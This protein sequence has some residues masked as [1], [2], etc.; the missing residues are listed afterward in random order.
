MQFALFLKW[1]CIVFLPAQHPLPLEN[2][3]FPL[4]WESHIVQGS[5]PGFVQGL[6][7]RLSLCVNPTYKDRVG[8]MKRG[9]LRMTPSSDEKWREKEIEI[10]IHANIQPCL[11][12]AI[13]WSS[14]LD[15][16]NF[17]FVLFKLGFLNLQQWLAQNKCIISFIMLVR[18]RKW[19][20]KKRLQ[21]EER[22][23]KTSKVLPL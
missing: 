4:L 19:R 7:Q 13:L 12:P 2:Q 15:K 5:M 3:P 10:N 16:S 23:L 14:K 20:K 17:P 6:W 11:K 22:A 18:T 1:Q 21:T 9:C 8:Y